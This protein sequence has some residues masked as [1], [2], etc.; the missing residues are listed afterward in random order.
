MTNLT[1]ARC[2]QTNY[3]V[4]YSARDGENRCANCLYL[5]NNQK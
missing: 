2:G 5:P 4:G 1:C 3:W